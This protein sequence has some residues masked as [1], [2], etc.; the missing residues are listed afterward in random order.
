MESGTTT[1]KSRD[2]L[3]RPWQALVLFWL[4]VVAIIVAGNAAFGSNLRAIVWSVGPGTIGTACI[5]N[6]FRC[7]RVHC[8][9][10]GPYFLLM[11]LVTLFYRLGVLPLGRNGWNLIGLA[12]LVGG[13]ALCCLPE[14]FLGK[15]RRVRNGDSAR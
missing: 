2:I 8:Y 1:C 12:T 10:S 4:P 6:A 11:A 7:G 9:L 3:K 14:M 13:I 15:Y 5:V